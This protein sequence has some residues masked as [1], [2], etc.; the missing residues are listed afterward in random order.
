MCF[1]VARTPTYTHRRHYAIW[2]VSIPTRDCASQQETQNTGSSASIG[3]DS[4]DLATTLAGGGD[5]DNRKPATTRANLRSHS[6]AIDF[7]LFFIFGAH[8]NRAHTPRHVNRKAGSMPAAGRRERDRNIPVGGSSGK[9]EGGKS[10]PR[11][12]FDSV[13]RRVGRTIGR[14]CRDEREPPQERPTK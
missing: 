10:V 7:F 8:Q 6:Q 2:L 13:H 9:R 1:V 3:R 5:R 12:A 14:T 11:S 4:S